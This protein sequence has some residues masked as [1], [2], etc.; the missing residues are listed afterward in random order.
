M[1]TTIQ[2]QTSY[3]KQP[4]VFSSLT[5]ACEKIPHLNYNKLKYLDLMA[6]PFTD[7]FGNDLSREPFNETL[8]EVLAI[9]F[10]KRKDLVVSGIVPLEGSGEMIIH[11]K[12]KK[13]RY[14]ISTDYVFDSPFKNP[15]PEDIVLEWELKTLTDSGGFEVNYLGELRSILNKKIHEYVQR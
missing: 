12:H 10:F 15:E 8:N 1:R 9:K 4:F 6:E 2:Y 11:F 7:E 13:S 14:Q 3:Q 5:I